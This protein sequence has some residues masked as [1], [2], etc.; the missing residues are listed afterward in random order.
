M[1]ANDTLF[2]LHPEQ[3]DIDDDCNT[4]SIAQE[5][6]TDKAESEWAKYLDSPKK[7]NPFD[8]E[9]L[10]SD[11]IR[12]AEH[13]TNEKSLYN[14]INNNSNNFENTVDNRNFG[15]EDIAETEKLCSTSY[16]YNSSIKDECNLQDSDKSSRD[17]NN[18]ANIFETYS[19]LDDPLDI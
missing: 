4:T 1:K 16:N 6:G 17:H 10:S 19:E 11:D 14:A 5:S 7:E 18:V 2:S 3:K 15:F 12:K 9:D 13:I 8:A